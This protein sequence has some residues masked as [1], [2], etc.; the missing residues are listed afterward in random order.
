MIG[1][2]TFEV[3]KEELLVLLKD[4]RA[5]HK[6]EYD[7]AVIG[8]REEVVK[9]LR[10]KLVAALEGKKI[11]LGTEHSHPTLHTAGYDDVIGL[12][13]L[14][15]EDVVD[16]DLHDYKQ[17]VKDEWNWK[18]GWEIGNALYSTTALSMR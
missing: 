2:Q 16:L 8:F 7:I 18:G 17:Y 3:V 6:E 11:V 1:N 15:T 4:N 10:E 9:E 12:L 14:T 5:K 13:E